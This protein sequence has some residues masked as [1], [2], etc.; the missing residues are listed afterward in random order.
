MDTDV[1]KVWLTREQVAQR[2]QI[3]VKTVA[4]WGRAGYGPPYALIGRHCRYPLDR[5]IDWEQALLNH[6]SQAVA[7]EPGP[8]LRIAETT[9]TTNDD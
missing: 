5:L 7:T 1:P 9:V 2:L 3:P 8:Y 4:E 6:Q